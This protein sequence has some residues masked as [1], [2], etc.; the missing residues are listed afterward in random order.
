MTRLLPELALATIGVPPWLTALSKSR[1]F[2]IVLGLIVWTGVAVH[3]A[4]RRG[5]DRRVTEQAEALADK[6]DE[7]DALA[8]RHA[9]DIAA[10][11]AKVKSATALALS[12]VPPPLDA[13]KAVAPPATPA[14]APLK[15]AKAKPKPVPIATASVNAPVNAPACVP[16]SSE[17]I[18]ALNKIRVGM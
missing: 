11:E 17:A 6:N 10:L 16:L 12:T 18:A 5:Y 15:K 1:A 14:P 9:T 3:W 2:W 4:D 7:I 8:R 13:F